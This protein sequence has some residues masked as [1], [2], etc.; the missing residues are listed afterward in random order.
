MTA[1]TSF[2]EHNGVAYEIVQAFYAAWNGSSS[3]TTASSK[4][5]L[6]PPKDKLSLKLFG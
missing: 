1:P 6:N 4:A 2:M 5:A 3:S